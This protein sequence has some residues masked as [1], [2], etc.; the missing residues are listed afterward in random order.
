MFLAHSQF[1]SGREEKWFSLQAEWLVLIQA[2]YHSS[3]F[4]QF[5]LSFQR[6]KPKV[7]YPKLELV[8]KKIFIEIYLLMYFYYSCICFFCRMYCSTVYM[9]ILFVSFK[10]G[11]NDVIGLH[12]VSPDGI[13]TSLDTSLN[14]FSSSL[15]SLGFGA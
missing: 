3:R 5:V 1:F 14:S 6:W 9:N 12:P 13:F 7:N 8:T 10:G 4:K 15:S 2:V 11:Y